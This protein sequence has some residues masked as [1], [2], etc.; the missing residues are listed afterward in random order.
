[1]K[2]VVKTGTGRSLT[3]N[4]LKLIAIAAMTIDH[5]TW[6]LFPGCQTVWYVVALHIV[7]RLTAPIMWFF[8]AEGSFYTHN[9]VRYILRLLGFSVVSHFAYCFAFGIPFLPLSTGPFNQTSVLWSLTIAAALIAVVRSERV[10][11]WAKYVCIFAACLLAFPSDWSSIAV[12]APLFLYLHRGDFRRQALD[13]VLWTA[14]YALVYVVF[15][16]PVY[17]VLQM[18]TVLSVP[19][20]RLYKGERGRAKGAKGM[21]WLFYIYY[22]AHLVVVGLVRL[23]LHGDVSIIF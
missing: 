10:P 9:T 23:A 8:I 2:S 22:P 12:M 18:F 1:M 17:G 19:L 6:A 15:L 3:A 14:V 7:G 20:L 16:H 21:K 4:Q 13:I 5:L 11:G